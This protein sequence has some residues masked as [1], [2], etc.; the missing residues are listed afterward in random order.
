MK[1]GNANDPD[2][3]GPV[4]LVYEEDM[5]LDLLDVIVKVDEELSDPVPDEVDFHSPSW[6]DDV[7]TTMFTTP[8][9]RTAAVD[10][11]QSDQ[12]PADN[13][14][15]TIDIPVCPDSTIDQDVASN[16]SDKYVHDGR[17]K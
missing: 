11:C 14:M 16:L 7:G 3:L 17:L 12:I 4:K 1:E 2:N 10:A 15:E 13:T 5:E 9:V 8:H 6:D